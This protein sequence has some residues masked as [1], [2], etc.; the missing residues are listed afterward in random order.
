MISNFFFLNFLL[1]VNISLNHYSTNKYIIYIILILNVIVYLLLYHFKLMD[2][3]KIMCFMKFDIIIKHT[4]EF[5]LKLY[6]V[7]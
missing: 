3:I 2:F 6:D 1:T 4:N 5:Y 7:F